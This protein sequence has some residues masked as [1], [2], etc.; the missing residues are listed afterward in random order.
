MQYIT[1]S[2][3]ICCHGTYLH[4]PCLKLM[5][6]VFEHLPHNFYMGNF[7]IPEVCGCVYWPLALSWLQEGT[8]AHPQWAC[9]MTGQYGFYVNYHFLTLSE[10]S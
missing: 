2:G 10:I 5:W 7:L 4:V 9:D 3:K 6:K 8:L 1:E